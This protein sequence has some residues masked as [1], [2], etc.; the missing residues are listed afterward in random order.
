MSTLTA[1]TA[2]KT[3]FDANWSFTARAFENESAYPPTGASGSL[4]AFVHLAVRGE[5]F[6]QISIGSSSNLQRER[7]RAIFMCCVETGAGADL[8]RS[9][10][11]TLAKMMKGLVLP[12]NV[13]CEDMRVGFGEAF[14]AAGNYWGVPLIT[15]WRRDA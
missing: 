15:D 2:L 13:F 8:P 11:L 7:G 9:Y 10:A 6:R 4:P 1:Y 14:A 5:A 12:P 3:W